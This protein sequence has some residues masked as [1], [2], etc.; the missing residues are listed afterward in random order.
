MRVLHEPGLVHAPLASACT[1]PRMYQVTNNNTPNTAAS[2]LYT[3]GTQHG[4][5][6]HAP[7]H[8]QRPADL[9]APTP[10]RKINRV[11]SVPS[12]LPFAIADK[13]R[14]NQREGASISCTPLSQHE[15][16]GYLSSLHP[17]P[18][19]ALLA[20]GLSGGNRALAG[21]GVIL[22][23][24]PGPLFRLAE[25]VRSDCSIV[26]VGAVSSGSFVAQTSS[27]RWRGGVGRAKGEEQGREQSVALGPRYILLSGGTD[28]PLVLPDDA[29]GREDGWP[30]K[31]N[32]TR[33]QKAA[34]DLT[35]VILLTKARPTSEHRP[36]FSCE[37]T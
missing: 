2:R 10:S 5:A 29:R 37:E 15:R 24:V 34:R 31:H 33:R 16:T 9:S 36:S 3:H 26:A 30:P 35:S 18:T 28:A 23:P 12:P 27:A 4:P 32:G 17:S 8:R 14:P 20:C 6:C 21:P 25:R 19:P 13:R 7:S 11:G 22:P 1:R